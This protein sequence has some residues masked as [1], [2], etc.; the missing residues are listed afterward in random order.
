MRDQDEQLTWAARSWFSASLQNYI[1]WKNNFCFVWTIS[2][3]ACRREWQRWKH[4]PNTDNKTKLHAHNHGKHKN[5]WNPQTLPCRS[6]ALH[7]KEMSHVT[8]THV[9]DY[10][11]NAT[12]SFTTTLK[13]NWGDITFM[14]GPLR[15]HRIPQE[16]LE[17]GS[18]MPTLQLS[19]AVLFLGILPP[20]LWS[21]WESQKH[22]SLI[23]VRA[24]SKFP[25]NLDNILLWASD[26]KKK[27]KIPVCYF[28][29]FVP[30]NTLLLSTDPYWQ[31]EKLDA[32]AVEMKTL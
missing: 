24:T 3:D 9:A 5:R 12:K 4:L 17:G 23:Y 20:P 30:I 2:G 22:N 21:H 28:L 10:T 13:S 16:T 7:S 18:T 11:Y 1:L 14:P 31:G 6:P 25:R 8:L 19:E 29:R 32:P 27:N 26:W 15:P